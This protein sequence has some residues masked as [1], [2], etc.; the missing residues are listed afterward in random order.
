MKRWAIPLL[1]V[2][3]AAALLAAPPIAQ[4]PGYHNFA[5]QR[6]A[7]GVPHA[8]DVLTNLPFL[9]VGW[10]GLRFLS[11]RRRD[12]FHDRREA[13]GYA[14]FFASVLLTGLGSAW[15]HWAPDSTRLFWDRLP[16]AW[17]ATSLFCIVIAE[18][19]S[20]ALGSRLLAPLLAFGA[21]SVVFWSWTGDLRLYALVQ[22]FPVAGA[23]LLL[24]LYPPRYS[25]S[26][27]YWG[28]IGWYLLAKLCE[29]LDGSI[30]ALNGLVT[31]HNL[32]HLFAAAATAWVL[33]MLM[34]RR[35]IPVLEPEPVV[36]PIVR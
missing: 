33:R 7:L 19:A 23:A 22:Y 28:V 12:S 5:D 25:H 21:G 13:S 34:R 15:Y 27:H 2:T 29:M 17:V 14:V 10:A 16:L 35:P 30:F 6:T 9:I 1:A 8:G 24:L 3:A 4:D 31:G 20:P 18:R 36:A 26:G 11:R 32:K